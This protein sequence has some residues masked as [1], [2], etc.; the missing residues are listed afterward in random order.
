VAVSEIEIPEFAE[1]LAASSGGAAPVLID[2]READEYAAGHVA[3]ARHIPLAEIPDHLDAFATDGP[4]YV[5]CQAGGRSMSAA[6]F[7]AQHGRET[8]NVVGGTGAWIAAGH[9][10]V[11]GDSPS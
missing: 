8:V 3:G 5:I 7:A 1:L 2:V 11:V 9:A 10:V 6:E 4:T